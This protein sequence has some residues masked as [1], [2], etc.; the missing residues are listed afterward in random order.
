MS[1]TSKVDPNPGSCLKGKLER[2]E[3]GGLIPSPL[4]TGI[5]TSLAV[6]AFAAN[7]VLA[8]MALVSGAVDPVG[9]TTVRLISGAVTLWLVIA[10]RETSPKAKLTG[11]WTS[12]WWLVVYAFAFALA[13]VSLPAGTGALI[14]F[15]VVQ[16]TM[17]GAGL[18]GGERPRPLRWLGLGI[19][20]AGLVV[21]TAPDVTG[22]SPTGVLMMALAGI[23][24][25]V[26]SIRGRGAADPGAVTAGNFLRSLPMVMLVA[27]VLYATR[28][29]LMS[30]SWT[31]LFLAVLSG[32]LASGVGYVIWYTALRGLS[33]TM[34]A[35]V[36]LAVPVLAALG[37][38]IFLSEEMTGRLLL[39]GGTILA[40]VAISGL[41]VD[42]AVV[43][44]ES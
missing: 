4:R 13:Y 31:G 27:V 3:G 17:I 16:I 43:K 19:A 26:Y 20:F 25:G 36:Q 40:G 32:S 9:F 2:V 14:L 10:L 21:L 39:V 22:A 23:A 7:S 37:G 33:A 24:W 18:W 38:V 34:A 12:A 42:R 5:L 8:R 41:A 11:S 35:I 29:T 6:V 28:V 30:M 15:A 44:P 1:D